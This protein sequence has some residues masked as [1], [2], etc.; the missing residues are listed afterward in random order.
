MKEVQIS[1]YDKQI[2]EDHSDEAENKFT[3]TLAFKNDNIYIAY[4]DI[5][6]DVTTVV[7]VKNNVVYIKRLGSVKGSLEFN[8]NQSNKTLYV[9]PYGEMEMEIMT[10]RCDIYILEKGVKIYIEYKIIMQDAKISDNIY[11]IVTN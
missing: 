9:T 11:M 7:K 10:K 6:Q 2:Y 8:L 5:E 3:G 1:V 4:K